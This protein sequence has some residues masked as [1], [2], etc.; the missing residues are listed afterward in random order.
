M[1]GPRSGIQA[2][3]APAAG[4][5]LARRRSLS[6][7]PHAPGRWRIRA[8]PSRY[9]A[10]G[11]GGAYDRIRGRGARPVSSDGGAMTR[12]LIHIGFPKAGSTFL[13]HWFAAHPQIAYAKGGNAGIEG[14]FAIV[15]AALSPAAPQ[16]WRVTSAEA[17]TAPLATP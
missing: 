17:L 13:Q 2:S 4:R 15:D 11:L 14:A 5:L 8:G 10:L 16:R 3:S 12:H 9:P 6:W 1:S 7:R